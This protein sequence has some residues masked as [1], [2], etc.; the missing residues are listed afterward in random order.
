M[1]FRICPFLLAGFALLSACR[2][3]I[4]PEEPIVPVTSNLNIR[5]QT[6]LLPDTSS[7]SFADALFVAGNQIIY[8]VNH[9]NPSSTIESRN[10]ET[11]ELNWMF[12]DFA[13]PVWGFST[14]WEGQIFKYQDN[15]IIGINGKLYNV[16]NTNGQLLWSSDM[17]QREGNPYVGMIGDYIYNSHFE[18]PSPYCTSVSPIRIRL[19]SGQ[20]DTLFTLASKNDS[21]YVDLTSPAL[22][23]NPVGDS[24]LLFNDRQSRFPLTPTAKYERT[25]L[26][27]FN[28]RTRQMIWESIDVNPDNFSMPQKSYIFGNR[29]YVLGGQTVICIDMLDGRILWQRDINSDLA[30]CN[31]VD[32]GNAII[33]H[34][35]FPAFGISA[36]DKETGAIKW[37]NPDTNGFIYKLTLSEGVV[38]FTNSMGIIHAVDAETGKTL[39][40]EQSPYKKTSGSPVDTYKF[41]G[42]AIDEQR[43]LL[44]V[45]DGYYLYCFELPPK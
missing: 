27:A 6:P 3:E 28:L 36:L 7:G 35:T 1:R 19:M 42:L 14:W 20:I 12:D 15:T 4:Q 43:R 34:Y 38:Y 29:A 9:K 22:W 44:F 41:N 37:Q 45:A 33:V 26:Y 30:D 21:F 17:G 39:W 32:Y 13:Y 23:I 31:I 8:C 24:V 18:C 16:D 25:N 5:W 40:K 11:G 2:P 10:I